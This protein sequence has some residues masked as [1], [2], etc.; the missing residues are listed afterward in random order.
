MKNCINC[1]AELLDG[2]KFCFSCGKRQDIPMPSRAAKPQAPALKTEGKTEVP[3]LNA[4]PQ[5]TPTEAPVIEE[6]PAPTGDDNKSEAKTDVIS[7]L[8]PN[9]APEASPVSENLE[10]APEKASSEPTPVKQT[11]AE[12]KSESSRSN[13]TEEYISI[14]ECINPKNS[15]TKIA[16]V[17]SEAQI[18]PEKAEEDESHQPDYLSVASEP[19]KKPA[20][21]VEF[22]PSPKK[23]VKGAAMLLISIVLLIMAFL[24]IYSI[25]CDVR[26]TTIEKTSQMRMSFSAVDTIAIFFNS[27]KSLDDEQIQDL[28]LDMMEEEAFEIEKASAK[29][30]DIYDIQ[31]DELKMITNISSKHATKSFI[32]VVASERYNTTPTLVLAT[33][34]AFV[35]LLAVLALFIMSIFSLM[36]ALTPINVSVRIEKASLTLISLLPILIGTI[37]YALSVIIGTPA[38]SD[39][40]GVISSVGALFIDASAHL[41]SGIITTIV[42]SATVAV[43]FLAYG[44]I[45]HKRGASHISATR[46][47]STVVA[48]ILLVMLALPISVCTVDTLFNNRNAEKEVKIGLDA[49]F[50]EDYMNVSRKEIREEGGLRDRN[51][52]YEDLEDFQ[53]KNELR[54]FFAD[55]L[56]TKFGA[57]TLFEVSRGEADTTNAQFLREFFVASGDYKDL[58]V[59]LLIPI[60]YTLVALGAL[61]V[62]WQN[63]VY[64]AFGTRMKACAVI[65]K[66]IALVAA[67][68]SIA[69]FISFM[70]LAGDAVSDYAPGGYMISIGAGPILIGVFALALTCIPCKSGAKNQPDIYD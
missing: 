43:G 64:V 51:E 69:V 39:M 18:Q 50:F 19:E 38:A 6:N 22:K 60:M 57:Y 36:S 28:V 70:I 20:K 63:V 47:A 61:L 27:T 56:D 53:G 59:Y 13:V 7:S 42:I 32:K 5:A 41:G 35:Y 25:K 1:G 11:V 33:V 12:V 8:N 2:A 30:D 24:P 34:I 9:K 21:A 55:E 58:G 40:N 17:A 29:I 31:D 52:S 10:S 37:W 45:S 4:P 15:E 46:I 67:V 16:S 48:V 26:Y 68:V 54:K 3:E 65:G 66:I 23:I 62:I 44:I 14:S 49:G